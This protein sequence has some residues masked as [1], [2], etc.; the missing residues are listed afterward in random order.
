MSAMKLTILTL[1]VL[2]SDVVGLYECNFD[3]CSAQP[4]VAD[5]NLGTVGNP[6]PAFLVCSMAMIDGVVHPDY[7]SGYTLSGLLT[8]C[9]Q[10]CESTS[11]QTFW[12]GEDG[13][14]WDICGSCHST[15]IKDTICNNFCLGEETPASCASPAV[16][17]PRCTFAAGDGD[18]TSETYLGE[19]S[20]PASCEARV[21][22]DAPTA[23]GATYGGVTGTECWA[24]FGMT[25]IIDDPT[26]QTCWMIP[27]QA[28]ASTTTSTDAPIATDESTVETTTEEP[29]T[30]STDVAETGPQNRGGTTTTDG[31]DDRLSY[32]SSSG[33]GNSGKSNKKGKK[34]KKQGKKSK[35][36]KKGKKSHLF[37][38][39]ASRGLTP[40]QAGAIAGGALLVVAGALV[41]TVV[42]RHQAHKF[43]EPRLVEMN[44]NMAS[45]DMKSDK[46]MER[47]PLLD[48]HVGRME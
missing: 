6:G 10:F 2:T 3:E 5:P 12:D 8:L 14:V 1:A 18:A 19:E 9:R 30:T 7:Q 11:R 20:D 29:T 42:K 21:I 26:F 33:K 28:D 44:P 27:G 41:G 17:T 34:N 13:S 25:G 45:I 47:M 40:T 48:Q 23:T 22:A 36:G 4:T 37:S 16:R 32:G 35:K 46:E 43:V 31:P 15:E 38:V 39:P 24:E